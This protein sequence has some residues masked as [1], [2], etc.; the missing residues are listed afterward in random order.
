MYIFILCVYKN[1]HFISL[2]IEKK[3]M[4]KNLLRTNIQK[5]PSFLFRELQVI[6]VLHFYDS[7]M[8]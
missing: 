4:L 7:Y 6:A 2:Y 3:Q 5:M 1:M 8:N